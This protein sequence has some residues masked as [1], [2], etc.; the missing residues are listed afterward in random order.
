MRFTYFSIEGNLLKK[1]D[2]THRYVQ[3]IYNSGIVLFKFNKDDTNASKEILA[4]QIKNVRTLD[5]YSFQITVDRSI[6]N[7]QAFTQ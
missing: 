4:N 1:S 7:L 3:F 2:Q 5:Q 6:L